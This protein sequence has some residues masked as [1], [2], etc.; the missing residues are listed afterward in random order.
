MYPHCILFTLVSTKCPLNQLCF[1]ILFSLAYSLCL[2]KLKKW[3]LIRWVPLNPMLPLRP[4]MLLQVLIRDGYYVIQCIPLCINVVICAITKKQGIGLTFRYDN[5][6]LLSWRPL[7]A[8]QLHINSLISLH[9]DDI[10]SLKR[11]QPSSSTINHDLLEPSDG[12]EVAV[13]GGASFNHEANVSEAVF[14]HLV[15][16]GFQLQMTRLHC[17]R[18]QHLRR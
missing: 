7:E 1:L 2:H 3:C 16:N 17:N 10:K 9:L 11:F 15:P 6:W 14:P 5:K 13:G 18:L 8:V 4:T 12:A